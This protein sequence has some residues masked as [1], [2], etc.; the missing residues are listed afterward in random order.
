LLFSGLKAITPILSS[1]TDSTSLN[2]VS[3]QQ[4]IL[5]CPTLIYENLTT[6]NIQD[7]RNFLNV[8]ILSVTKATTNTK[9]K[10]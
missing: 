10:I 4:I 3:Y 8:T 5:K 6:D 7:N 2:M 9:V 1:G